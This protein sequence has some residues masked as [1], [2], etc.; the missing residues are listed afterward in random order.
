MAD[1][2][3]MLVAFDQLTEDD[4]EHY[5]R[6]GMKWYKHIYGEE[7]GAAKYMQ[8]GRDK[9]AKLQT[10]A[11][12]A[13]AKSDLRSKKAQ[14]RKMQS[15]NLF[16]RGASERRIRRARRRAWKLS[17]KAF[18]LERKS[19]RATK[20]A[21]KILK[22]VSKFELQNPNAGAKAYVDDLVK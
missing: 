18:R 1:Y 22:K 16:D 11:A 14:Y 6:L 17:R 13:K 9:A 5:G 20:K 3:S 12:K 4:L 8:K 10:K 21:N 2:D 19:F 7:Q 15:E